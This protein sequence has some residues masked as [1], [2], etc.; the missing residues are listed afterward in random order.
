MIRLQPQ[1]MLK[2]C[3]RGGRLACP[4]LKYTEIVP[5]VR[6]A[7]KQLECNPLFVDR[8]PNISTTSENLRKRGMQQRIIRR[9]LDSFSQ[10]RQRGVLVAVLG[11]GSGKFLMCL[12]GTGMK[13]GGLLEKLNRRWKIA[14][15][16]LYLRRAKKTAQVS[17]G[18]LKTAGKL[19][20]RLISPLFTFQRCAKTCANICVLRA[21]ANLGAKVSLGTR[22]L[23]VAQ[24]NIGEIKPGVARGRIGSHR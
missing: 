19:N 8:L 3:A 18:Y 9:Q 16:R 13:I 6:I 20:L 7:I 23:L 22:E 17:R 2:I 11:I 1:G 10:L 15:F 12:G 4:R 5:A 21:R 14:G 24:F